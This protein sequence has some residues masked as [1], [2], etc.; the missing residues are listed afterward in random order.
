[1]SALI[2]VVPEGPAY[3]GLFSE[4]VPRGPLLYSILSITSILINEYDFML[5]GQHY[6]GKSIIIALRR[7]ST[8]HHR[9]A[10]I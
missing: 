9:T 7:L 5:I 2:M 6:A 4:S 8:L 10:I 3:P 1:M